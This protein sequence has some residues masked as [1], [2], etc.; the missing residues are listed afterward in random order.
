MAVGGC[1]ERAGSGLRIPGWHASHRSLF[2]A[3]RAAS[4]R[5][6]RTYL[7]ARA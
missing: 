4:S 2:P 7:I 1:D 3:L 5:V 6:T